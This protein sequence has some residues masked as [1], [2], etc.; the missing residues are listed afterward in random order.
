MYIASIVKES[1]C[2]SKLFFSR[3]LIILTQFKQFIY[4]DFL[5]I[6]L[7]CAIKNYLKN[8]EYYGNVT[9]CGSFILDGGGG[10]RGVE[11]SLWL[12][13]NTETKPGAGLT[14]RTTS[15]N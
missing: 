4:Q 1:L 9:A 5:K 13:N 12:V 8:H 2:L 10:E 14:R 7:L 3:L 11:V 15:S 6:S